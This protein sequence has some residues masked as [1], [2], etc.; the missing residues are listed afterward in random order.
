VTRLERFAAAALQGLLASEDPPNARD[1]GPLAL[2][3]GLSLEHAFV[4]E[5]DPLD[6][7]RPPQAS[8]KEGALGVAAAGGE[9]SQEDPKP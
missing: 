6:S 1:A 9:R 2:R 5:V 8:R 4:T 3:F 7:P